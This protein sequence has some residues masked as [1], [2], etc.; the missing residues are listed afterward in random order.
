MCENEII[1]YHTKVIALKSKFD[2]KISGSILTGRRYLYH[3]KI[4]L[5]I[6]RNKKY[7][8]A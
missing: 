5:L 4:F 6:F 8:R 2:E 3:G 1:S 7:Y